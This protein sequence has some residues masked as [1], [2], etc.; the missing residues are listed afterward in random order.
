[1]NLLTWVATLALG[2]AG[3]TAMID[4]DRYVGVWFEQ[5]RFENF[6]EKGCAGVSSAYS[7]KPEGGLRVI[8]RCFQDGLDGAQK[9]AE[10]S[11]WAPDPKQPGKL[12]LQFFW[13]FSGDS[14]VLEVAPDYSWALVGNPAK[15]SAWVLSRKR[16]IDET[17]YSTLVEKLRARGYE[18]DKLI[19]VAQRAE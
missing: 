9:T 16:Q 13:P 10:G 11:A 18:V 17:L 12:K 7:K 8:N 1:L 4:F 2:Q 3:Q 5:A 15:S 14:W 6:F 19:R